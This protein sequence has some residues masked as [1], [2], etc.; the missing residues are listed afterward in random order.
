[1]T[2]FDEWK[3]N[4]DTIYA[5]FNEFA[6]GFVDRYDDIV[7]TVREDYKSMAK[8]VWARLYPED[9]H[10]ATESFVLN[11]VDEVA[12]KIPS[13]EEILRTFKYQMVYITIPMPS[14][15]ENNIAKA[16]EI[17]RESE[18]KEFSSDLE[19]ETKQRVADEYV[20]RKEEL[21]DGFLESTVSSMRHYIGDL[22]DS[23]L[24][25]INNQAKVGRVSKHHVKKINNMIDKIEFLNFYQDEEV[26]KL[27]NEL[28]NEVNKF[29]DQRDNDIIIDKLSEIVE[30]GSQDFEPN[31]N[32]AISSLEI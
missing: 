16:Q 31:Y 1:M 10:G 24:K 9:K 11:F 20:K 32:P 30:V 26:S 13:K 12:S 25:S 21:I 5:E 18:M 27:L 6:L 17:R 7:K 3:S 4:N 19:R 8:D 22:C 23:V 15:V 2:A 28:G 29:N 14:V